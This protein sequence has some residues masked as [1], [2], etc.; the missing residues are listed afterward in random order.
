MREY[1][2]SGL[3]ALIVAGLAAVAAAQPPS[4]KPGAPA[5]PATKAAVPPRPAILDQVLATVNGKSIIREDLYRFINATGIPPGAENNE[6]EIYKIG[7]ENLVN[8]ELVKQY[9]QKQKTL[10]VAEK[11]IDAEFADAEKRLKADGQDINVAIASAGLTVAKVREQMKELLRWNKYLDAV[12]TDKNLEAFVEKNKDVFNQTQVK[13][14]HI[15]LLVTPEITPAD[16]A[17]IKEKLTAIKRDIDAGKISFADAANKYSEDD[18]NKTSPNGGDLGYFPRRAYNEQ[19]T[20]AAFALPKGKVSDPVESPFG[21][22]LIL[23]TDRKEGT[24]VDFKA[25]KL[26]IRT[27]YG[28]DLSERIVAAERKTAKIDVKPMPADLFPKAPPQQP[29]A[30]PGQPPATKGA[31]PPAGSA[32]RPK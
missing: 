14:S 1:V 27:E 18:G 22:H 5:G 12:A 29:G 23:V 19:F 31:T 32:P 8:A 17:K 16:K 21:F 2:R 15:V 6:Q 25:K 3:V 30:T 7:I 26:A 9:L 4:T 10:E 28:A 24:P 20:T 11:D 13:A